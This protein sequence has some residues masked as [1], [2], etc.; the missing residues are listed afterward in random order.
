MLHS[1]IYMINLRNVAYTV[2]IIILS[3]SFIGCS[4]IPKSAVK[5]NI[6][7]DKKFS[8]SKKMLFKN[9]VINTVSSP[10]G[11]IIVHDGS[12]T[13]FINPKTKKTIK[14]FSGAYTLLGDFPNL[15]YSVYDKKTGK[16]VIK[17][18]T[19]S[20]KKRW[21]KSIEGEW[22]DSY[23]DPGSHN[24]LLAMKSKS[25]IT[26]NFINAKNG[27]TKWKNKINSEVSNLTTAIFNKM[28]LVAT[29][30]K[31]RIYKINGSLQSNI[32]LK[33]AD[34]NTKPRLL[35]ASKNIYA[36]TDATLYKFTPGLKLIKKYDLRDKEEVRKLLV[37]NDYEVLFVS[38]QKKSQ[39]VIKVFNRK[40][41]KLK[42]E[43]I[44]T[45]YDGYNDILVDNNILYIVNNNKLNTYEM[46]SGKK[47]RSAKLNIDDSSYKTLNSVFVYKDKII[48]KGISEIFAYRK[49]NLTQLWKHEEI[50]TPDRLF[51]KEKGFTAAITAGMGAFE[52]IGYVRVNRYTGQ[53]VYTKD[54]YQLRADSDLAFNRY[55]KSLNL[56]RSS[57]GNSEIAF[58]R[59][60]STGSIFL[61]YDAV[62]LLINLDTGKGKNIQLKTRDSRHC[63]PN[64]L[65][66]VNNRT[67]Y[68][69]YGTQNRLLRCGTL[70]QVD[71][72]KF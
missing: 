31:L 11:L 17:S 57:T 16:T 49:K 25:S 68:Q 24:L 42:F 19:P 20:G 36:I 23:M 14:K 66:D 48:L 3:I 58:I 53:R 60:Y 47:L 29:Y 39:A 45:T 34:K 43:K 27:K 7:I 52:R 63:Y 64:V 8:T 2:S 33:S 40:N 65:V 1:K 61:E 21:N 26:I 50:W 15:I 56:S 35:D 10:N 37:Y 18:I 41:N 4:T 54:S 69:A 30:N 6:H 72:I 13:T 32:N 46:K 55:L 5:P 44:I 22:L 28:M 9:D 59:G 51:R 38:R 62:V 70:N 12:K 71:V 67:I